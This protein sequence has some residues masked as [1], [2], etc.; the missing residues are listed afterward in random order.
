VL[1]LSWLGIR[2]SPL[3][4]AS[5]INLLTAFVRSSFF[6]L[7]FFYPCNGTFLVLGSWIDPTHI[8]YKKKERRKEEERTLMHLY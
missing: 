6:F 4:Y 3:L 2:V 7:P 5:F 1:E 8:I